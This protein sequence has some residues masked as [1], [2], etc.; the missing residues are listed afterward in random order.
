MP[1]G[2]RLAAN[3]WSTAV[4][5]TGTE[6]YRSGEFVSDVLA[7]GAG[8]PIA[9]FSYTFGATAAELRGCSPGAH[10]QE[11][12]SGVLSIIVIVVIQDVICHV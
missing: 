12:I 8:T 5:A 3:S 2:S 7:T 9:V 1:H 10:R 4:D 11:V 6:L